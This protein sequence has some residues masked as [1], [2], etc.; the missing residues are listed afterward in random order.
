[1]SCKK[2]CFARILSEKNESQDESNSKF[3]KLTG[4]KLCE[5]Q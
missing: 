5:L 1:M 2:E 4:K 3:Q